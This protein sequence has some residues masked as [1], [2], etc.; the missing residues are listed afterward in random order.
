MFLRHIKKE[1]RRQLQN[2]K[3]LNGDY[4][5]CAFVRYRIEKLTPKCSHCVGVFLEKLRR[6]WASDVGDAWFSLHLCLLYIL[7][8]GHPSFPVSSFFFYNF[9]PRPSCFI[10]SLL[11]H[12]EVILSH[13]S[14]SGPAWLVAWVRQPPP[15]PTPQP[16]PP[17]AYWARQ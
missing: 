3:I 13:S 7:A 9:F 14:V 17:W 8:I 12:A 10:H 15:P 5:M 16:Q 11:I 4:Y 6:I 1:E 2:L